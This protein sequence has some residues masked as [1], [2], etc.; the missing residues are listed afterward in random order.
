MVVQNVVLEHAKHCL[1]RRSHGGGVELRRGL[2]TRSRAIQ[3]LT[4]SPR[5]LATAESPTRDA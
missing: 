5:A 3:K 2:V 4:L 1:I